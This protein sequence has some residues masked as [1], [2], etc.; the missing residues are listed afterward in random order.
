MRSIHGQLSD[1]QPIRRTL[2]E[3][4]K[5]LRT[6]KETLATMKSHTSPALRESVTKRIVQL[7]AELRAA[8]V[9]K[10]AAPQKTERPRTPRRNTIRTL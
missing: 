3:K 8:P 4:K 2:E 7:E 9:L 10:S 6:L 5:Q 1:N